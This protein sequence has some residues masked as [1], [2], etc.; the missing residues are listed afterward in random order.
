[1]TFAEQKQSIK[2][3]LDAQPKFR[4][5]LPAP[6]KGDSPFEVVGINGYNIQIKKGES[7]EVP[8]S[9]YM[10]LQDAQII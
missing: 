4:V 2:Q 7:V 3:I 10:I 6:R 8:E 5:R 1:M 9:V